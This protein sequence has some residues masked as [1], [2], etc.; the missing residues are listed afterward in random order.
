MGMLIAA[1]GNNAGGGAWARNVGYSLDG[2]AERGAVAEFYISSVEADIIAGS[3]A[4]D[5]LDIYGSWQS[6]EFCDF[7]FRPRPI[8]ILPA[9]L[10]RRTTAQK[11]LTVASRLI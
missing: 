8:T 5:R 7:R 6:G 2:D 4:M 10:L 1:P 3:G 11:G 9:E